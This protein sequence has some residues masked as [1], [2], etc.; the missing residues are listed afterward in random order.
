MHSHA[1]SFGRASLSLINVGS[2]T[3]FFTE[4][5]NY[6]DSSDLAEW[7]LPSPGGRQH[8]VRPPSAGVDEGAPHLRQTMDLE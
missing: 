3:D 6:G 5:A 2:A 1:L 8:G 4:H 7:G